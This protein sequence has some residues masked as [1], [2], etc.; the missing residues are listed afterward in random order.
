MLV[1]QGKSPDAAR[2]QVDEEANVVANSNAVNCKAVCDDLFSVSGFWEG[3]ASR[4]TVTEKLSYE[5][6]KVKLPIKHIAVK[7]K[8]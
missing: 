5:K 4:K 6:P 3:M 8:L 7:L 2:H 1:S